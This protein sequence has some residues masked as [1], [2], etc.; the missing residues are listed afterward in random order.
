M[1]LPA[2]LFL[3]TPTPPL[4]VD[5]LRASPPL[6]TGR[7]PAWL[8][9]PVLTGPLGLGG[10]HAAEEEM[11]IRARAEIDS[12]EPLPLG[13][14]GLLDSPTESLSGPPT[15]PLD[16]ALR[17][18]LP[19]KLPPP[20][21]SQL[22]RGLMTAVTVDV[23]LLERAMVLLPFTRPGLLGTL[24]VMEPL[25]DLVGLPGA[26][27][28]EKVLRER[29]GLLPE[30][31]AREPLEGTGLFGLLPEGGRPPRNGVGFPRLSW[32]VALPSSTWLT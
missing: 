11:D 27:P 16:R 3:L 17:L 28:D 30:A 12:W 4:F 14:V 25:R 5:A 24:R 29:P 21:L 9:P 8:N 26:P 19:Q 32:R 2:L 22:V 7:D 6:D 15:L 23:V 20:A 10:G 13:R 1:P 31:L 18:D